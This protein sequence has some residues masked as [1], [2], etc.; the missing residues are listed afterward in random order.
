MLPLPCFSYGSSRLFDADF[1]LRKVWR[2]VTGKKCTYI[3]HCM[4]D[5][6]FLSLLLLTCL[7]CPSCCRVQYVLVGGGG[8]D[9]L[10]KKNCAA[11]G[12]SWSWAKLFFGGEEERTDGKS[13]LSIDGRGASCG[14]NAPTFLHFH[15]AVRSELTKKINTDSLERAGNPT[16]YS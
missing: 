7:V 16:R 4:H 2:K 11:T 14:E 9:V 5:A 12:D 6:F 1:C 3:S 15:K 10:R 8:K 13:G